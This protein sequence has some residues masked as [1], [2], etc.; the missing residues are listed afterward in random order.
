MK[1]HAEHC[2]EGYCGRPDTLWTV[3]ILARS[4]TKWKRE[5]DQRWTTMTSYINSTVG[6]RRYCQ[7]DDCK[8]GF[9]KDA[10][11]AG[12]LQVPKPASVEMLF[13]VGDRAFVPISRMC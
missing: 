5:C 6:I 10:S 11:F 9:L 2:V 4:F 12:H 13:T 8:L 3:N 1:G 7:D